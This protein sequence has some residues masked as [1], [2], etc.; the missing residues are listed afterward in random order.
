MIVSWFVV[1]SWLDLPCGSGQLLCLG[2]IE[3]RVRIKGVDA[4]SGLEC[5]EG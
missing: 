5:G 3:L 4:L 1:A 2:C